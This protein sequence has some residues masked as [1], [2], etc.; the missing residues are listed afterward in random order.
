[1]GSPTSPT[2][3]S[4]FSR[5]SIQPSSPVV[6]CSANRGACRTEV[7]KRLF[8]WP[9]RPPCATTARCPA[10]TRSIG[11]PVD[12]LRL[13]AR[14]HQDLPVLPPSP[15]PVRPLPCRP[16]SSPEVLAPAQSTQIPPRRIADEHHIP[17]MPTIAT[18]GPAPGH[19]SLPPKAHARHSRPAPPSTQIFALSYMRNQSVAPLRSSLVRPRRR[20]TT[21]GSCSATRRNPERRPG[22]PPARGVLV[23]AAARTQREPRR[24]RRKPQQAGGAP[25]PS[26]P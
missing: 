8:P 10:S 16:R 3:A 5:S 4:S 2:S 21:T 17:P 22:A 9:P 20:Q 13:G 15:V 12:G 7:A 6:P 14:R 18:I 25:D 1:M 11:A 26:H 24:D 19:M 23:F